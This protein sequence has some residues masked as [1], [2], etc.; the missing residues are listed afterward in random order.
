MKP[1]DRLTGLLDGLASDRPAPAS[2]SAAA[3]V[4]AI[5][6]ALLEKVARLSAR[7]WTGA[8]DARRHAQELR[9]RAEQ[10]VEEDQE[11]YLS[12]VAARRSGEGLSEAAS[13]TVD[14][15]LEIARASQQAAELALLLAREGN[16][17]LLADATTAAILAHAAVS[18]ATM[19]VQVNAGATSRDPRLDEALRLLRAAG[20]SVRTLSP[21]PD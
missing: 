18:A 5:S 2:G 19:L 3:A 20:D 15:P 11:A 10:L 16:Q 17:A 6:A 8:G 21:E 12:Y 13:R 1:E 14:V 9:M 7:R 4:A